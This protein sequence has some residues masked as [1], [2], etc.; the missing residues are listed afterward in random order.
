[1]VSKLP[2]LITQLEGLDPSVHSLD[3]DLNIIGKKTFFGK[4]YS[5]ILHIL[6]FG[7]RSLNPDLD[8]AIDKTITIANR[9]FNTRTTLTEEEYKELNEL[10]HKLKIIV[11]CNQGNRQARVDTTIKKIN[12]LKEKRFDDFHEVSSSNTKDQELKFVKT[13]EAYISKKQY[14]S[15][16]ESDSYIVESLKYEIL[17]MFPDMIFFHSEK[18]ELCRFL[19]DLDSTSF[20]QLLPQLKPEF[21]S[22]FITSYLTDD[23]QWDACRESH[24]VLSKFFNHIVNLPN[25]HPNLLAFVYALPLKNLDFTHNS[26]RISWLRLDLLDEKFTKILNHVVDPERLYLFQ[27]FPKFIGA[28]LKRESC[29]DSPLKKSLNTVLDNFPHYRELILQGFAQTNNFTFFKSFQGN[30]AKIIADVWAQNPSFCHDVF[31]ENKYTGFEHPFDH[32]AGHL[33][34]KKLISLLKPEQKEIIFHYDENARYG[35]SSGHSILAKILAE[36]VSGFVQKN[37][38]LEAKH[39]YDQA[40]IELK[41]YVRHTCRRLDD[42]VYSRDST[43]TLKLIESLCRCVS[44]DG[45]PVINSAKTGNSESGFAKFLAKCPPYFLV[46]FCRP[47][48][49]YLNENVTDEKSLN[50]II[51]KMKTVE[52]IALKRKQ[53]TDLE[54]EILE[55]KDLIE[56]IPSIRGKLANE[57]LI[58]EKASDFLSE[59]IRRVDVLEAII[60]MTN[61]N[62]IVLVYEAISSWCD[63]ISET[64]DRIKEFLQKMGKTVE[65]GAFTQ[66]RAIAWLYGKLEAKDLIELII[67]KE[68]EP[69]SLK[70]LFND[71]ETSDLTLVVEG[72]EIKAHKF[73]LGSALEFFTGFFELNQDQNRIE[74]DGFTYDQIYKLIELVYCKDEHCFNI[75]DA[76]N[77]DLMETLKYFN[78]G[79]PRLGL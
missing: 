50:L 6:T 1:M 2:E 24:G 63:K 28:T 64:Q 57:T 58:R 42:M 65:N 76:E 77:K 9:F 41:R 3:S 36:E 74:I 62:E 52:N 14:I 21:I 55:V 73:I 17:S 71:A 48:G 72:K 31:C 19:E 70:P 12:F 34:V 38:W 37:Q 67:S 35:E 75:Y 54:H 46:D 45:L 53:L 23:Q 61:P 39:H 4:V 27:N 13:Y 30:D 60:S 68:I 78:G 59:K 20:N 22:T 51:S 11:S 66:E 69:I 56:A 5:W 32:P 47:F 25:N 18:N 16:K 43:G 10:F 40:H 7:F 26:H 8:K 15:Y 79:T 44:V 33:L 29:Y 49:F